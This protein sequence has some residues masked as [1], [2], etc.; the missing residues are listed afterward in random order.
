MVI[1]PTLRGLGK[2]A[3]GVAAYTIIA[4]F[5][6]VILV[7]MLRAMIFQAFGTQWLQNH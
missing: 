1:G 7:A 6:G 4:L 2:F 3:I 5:V